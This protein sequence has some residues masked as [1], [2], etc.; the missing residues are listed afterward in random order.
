MKFS[1]FLL[2]IFLF[3]NSFVFS[4][5]NYLDSVFNVL[6][7]EK[8]DTEKINIINNKIAYYYENINPDSSLKYY[9]QSINIAHKIV[10]KSKNNELVFQTALKLGFSLLYKGVVY[11]RL[12]KIEHSKL[13]YNT[14][15][16]IATVLKRF[17]PHRKEIYQLYGEYYSDLGNYYYSTNDWNNAIYNFKLSDL[18]YRVIFKLDSMSSEGSTGLLM[19]NNNLANIYL[20]NSDYENAIKYYYKALAIKEKQILYKKQ[21]DNSSLKGISAIY[22]N[23]A[24]VYMSTS[25]YDKA[26]DIY[27]KSM[28]IKKQISDSIGIYSLN[29]SIGGVFIKKKDYNTGIEYLKKSIAYFEK[30]KE[31][32][33]LAR[34]YNNIGICYAN[35]ENYE[36][37]IEAYKKSL[38]Y[39]N[40]TK[41]IKGKVIIQIN[42]AGLYQKLYMKSTSVSKKNLNL[43][44]AFQYAKQAEENARKMNMYAELENI[45]NE[46]QSIYEDKKDYKTALDYAKLYQSVKDSMY[47]EEKTKAMVELQTQYETEKKQFMIDKL[48]KDNELKQAKLEKSEEQQKRQKTIIFSL[49]AIFVLIAISLFAI[50]R[51]YI[52]LKSAHVI[53]KQQKNEIENKNVQLSIAFEEIRVQKEEIET[54]RDIVTQ[55]KNQIEEIHQKQTES[56]VYAKYIQKAVMVKLDKV[57]TPEVNEKLDYM[58]LFKPKDIVSGDFYWGNYINNHLIIAVADCTGHGVPG[59]FMSMLGISL[60]H[61]IVRKKEITQTNQALAE[62]RNEIIDALQQKGIT[63]EQKDGMD[64][65]LVAINTDT[66]EMQFSGANNTLVYIPA[67]VTGPVEIKG[68][69]MPVAIYERMN[70]YT[71]NRIQLKPGDKFFM[72]T[73]GYK[74]Q[75][76]GNEGK[77]FLQKRFL[78]LLWENRDLSLADSKMLLES[79]INQWMQGN[80]YHYSQIDD[81]TVLGVKIN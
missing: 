28:D 57:F 74:D 35:T 32:R 6:K 7:A 58:L 76:G 23:L 1:Y 51:M 41:E 80:G 26:L 4:Q 69:K 53:L 20:Y 55:Q 29:A 24:N 14:G 42:L 72:S 33:M 5:N 77:K 49:I 25:E 27:Q 16:N 21:N 79:T 67:N 43:N 81:I 37:A 63:G 30:I 38:E 22:L 75:F 61:E 73:D 18:N 12:T 60:L 56:I 11:N 45:A 44:L 17:F 39:K 64:I 36:A 31:A 3:I 34:F 71:L 10:S 2:L 68:D 9:Q 78:Q 15:Y 46:L 59:A 48:N 70:E 40:I 47:G 52:K 19:A 66:L 65:G 8:S 50:S 54:Q 62:L 13:C